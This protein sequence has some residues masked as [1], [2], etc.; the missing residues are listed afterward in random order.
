MVLFED[1]GLYY[2]LDFGSLLGVIRQ[3]ALTH[4]DGDV[5]IGIFK[6]DLPKFLSLRRRIEKCGYRCVRFGVPEND[7]K[8]WWP[9]IHLPE[10]KVSKVEVMVYGSCR[11]SKYVTVFCG[12]ETSYSSSNK[13]MIAPRAFFETLESAEFEGEDIPVPSQV[14]R[15]LWLR[16]GPDWM[17]PDPNFYR[18]GS[19]SPSPVY[20]GRVER[21]NQ[22]MVHLDELNDRPARLD[23]DHPLL[24]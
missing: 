10:S 3:G 1:A 5:E 13:S 14:E 18:Y 20:K 22:I 4:F 23:A 6:E 19:I 11:N 8:W 21:L 24:L 12:C 7:P 9:I 15:Y 2:W 16:Y 17:I